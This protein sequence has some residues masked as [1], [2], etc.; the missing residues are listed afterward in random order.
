MYPFLKSLYTFAVPSHGHTGHRFLPLLHPMHPAY[1]CNSSAVNF[2]GN[3]L[4]SLRAQTFAGCN[5]LLLSS[6]RPLSCWFTSCRHTC[7]QVHLYS[8]PTFLGL[9]RLGSCWVIFPVSSVTVHPFLSCLGLCLILL[10]SAEPGIPLVSPF[11]RLAYE[12][13]FGTKCLSGLARPYFRC[14]EIPVVVVSLE[15]CP[16]LC[17]EIPLLQCLLSPCNTHLHNNC[18]VFAL[19][20]LLLLPE[21]GKHSSRHRCFHILVFGKCTAFYLVLK[22]LLILFC[23][24]CQRGQVLTLTLVHQKNK[25]YSRN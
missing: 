23:V 11:P 25:K 9:V 24:P 21:A 19:A 12:E 5:Y 4:L 16:S 22:C 13:G 15:C 8:I 10:L 14:I 2:R 20:L 7:T 6:L 1:A 17:G 3:L 18:L